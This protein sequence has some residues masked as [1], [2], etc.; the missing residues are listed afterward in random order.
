MLIEYTP[1]EPQFYVAPKTAWRNPTVPPAWQGHPPEKIGHVEDDE[2]INE[3][4][5]Q[6]F[7][8]SKSIKNHSLIFKNV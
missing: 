7:C 5:S 8:H 2:H 6:L 4:C 3:T 1:G